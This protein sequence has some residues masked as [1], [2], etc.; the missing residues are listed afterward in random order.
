MTALVDDLL[1]LLRGHRL[2]E[3]V[4][5]LYYDETPTGKVS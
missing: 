5:V 3:N 2:V 1:D 4:R